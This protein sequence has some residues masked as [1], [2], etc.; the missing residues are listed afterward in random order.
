VVYTYLVKS[1][2]K[3]RS[4]NMA[5][6]RCPQCHQIDQVQKVSALVD[7]GTARG[8]TSRT[9]ISSRT[10]L[11]ADLR[12]PGY[13]PYDEEDSPLWEW[14]FIVFGFLIGYG[15]VIVGI[16]FL[17]I[18]AQLGRGFNFFDLGLIIVGVIIAWYTHL[19][20]RD[21]KKKPRRV[22]IKG[23]ATFIHEKRLERWDQL[24]YCFRDDGVFLP[25]GKSPFIPRS[26]MQNFVR[27][28]Y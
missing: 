1:I 27:R 14:G 28:S 5:D 16:V 15:L 12:P 11:S 23:A 13:N 8:F 26:E 4:R 22:R 3:E 2:G 17:V 9:S 19:Q 18:T 20:L 25:D 24:Y 10:D 6:I 7:A 21:M